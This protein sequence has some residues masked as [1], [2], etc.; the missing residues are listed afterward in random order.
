M[1][2]GLSDCYNSGSNPWTFG[3]SKLLFSVVSQSLSLSD[4]LIEVVPAFAQGRASLQIGDDRRDAE[5]DR[6][7]SSEFYESAFGWLVVMVGGWIAYL[8]LMAF[9]KARTRRS[10]AR[11]VCAMLM[12]FGIA[13][14]GALLAIP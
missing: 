1:S 3:V 7:Y 8:G 6:K 2:Q 12:G 13:L 11:G 10:N 14:L 9:A 4:S 5:N